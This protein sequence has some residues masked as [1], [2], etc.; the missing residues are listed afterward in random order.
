MIKKLIDGKI[1]YITTSNDFIYTKIGDVYAISGMKRTFDFWDHVV[2]KTPGIFH[3][4]KVT[5]ISETAFSKINK[6]S[7][8]IDYVFAKNNIVLNAQIPTSRVCHNIKDETF[9]NFL[10]FKDD[11]LN[12]YVNNFHNV[13]LVLNDL[14]KIDD[15]NNFAKN[16]IDVSFEINKVI[17]KQNRFRQYIPISITKLI[18]SC[19]K[20]NAKNYIANDLDKLNYNLCLKPKNE[21]PLDY[22]NDYKIAIFNE[23]NTNL[24]YKAL[25]KMNLFNPKSKPIS[26]FSIK[27]KYN[28]MITNRDDFDYFNLSKEQINELRNIISSC[29]NEYETLIACINFC[30]GKYSCRR[31]KSND[32]GIRNY[33]E[34]KVGCCRHMAN[35]LAR[36]LQVCGFVNELVVLC[37]A[38]YENND[39]INGFNGH[40]IN[41]I[42]VKSFHCWIY[43]D[44]TF[45][46]EIKN[47]DDLKFYIQEANNLLINDRYT[48]FQISGIFIPSD[49]DYF[50]E[51]Q[52]NYD[53]LSYLGNGVWNNSIYNKFGIKTYSDTELFNL[54]NLKIM[55]SL[56]NKPLNINEYIDISK[57]KSTTRKIVNLSFKI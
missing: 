20:L 13:V 33:L 10:I 43:L 40:I 36:I 47:I 1:T 9:K 34:H 51:F 30:K 11:V 32:Y 4:L 50:K 54:V 2:I 19:Y 57:I 8:F 23:F 15:L 24:R 48:N 5:T 18:K 3:D 12:K 45:I 14:F 55:V 7:I 27:Y 21:L 31:N 39:E 38:F 26:F 37:N 22:Y 53:A 49:T 56:I 25:W 41:R 35:T 6:Y 16:F 52:N 29:K 44:L 17:Y 42:Y 28:N 46:D